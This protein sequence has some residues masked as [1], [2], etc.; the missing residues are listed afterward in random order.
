MTWL[1]GQPIR[2]DTDLISALTHTPRMPDSVFPWSTKDA[3]P[4]SALM[5]CLAERRPH[6]MAVEGTE[7]FKLNNLSTKLRIMYKIVMYRIQP[8]KSKN[9]IT[10]DQ[11]LYLYAILTRRPIDYATVIITLMRQVR[12][13]MRLPTCHSKR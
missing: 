9:P 12:V 4:R 6:A 3:L 10:F 5:E 13:A 2:I 11:A 7:G 1:Q 8:I